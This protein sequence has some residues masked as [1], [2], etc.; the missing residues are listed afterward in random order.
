MDDF[1]RAFALE[2]AKREIAGCGDIEKLREVA[3]QMLGLMEHQKAMILKMA[4]G[5]FLD[6]P[7]E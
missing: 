4:E 7:T 1:S 3:L 2:S 6:K 5:Y